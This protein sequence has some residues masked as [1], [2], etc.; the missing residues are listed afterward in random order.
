MSAALS[1]RMNWLS[2]I[3]SPVSEGN[4]AAYPMAIAIP[5]GGLCRLLSTAPLFYRFAAHRD[6]VPR[7][8]VM[9]R[10]VCRKLEGRKLRNE[11]VAVV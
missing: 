5:W 2:R 9:Y 8:E 7:A 4:V 11:G 10:Q 1:G 3:K 6:A